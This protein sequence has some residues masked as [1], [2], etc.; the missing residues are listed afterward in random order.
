[1]FYFT[2]VQ[3]LKSGDIAIP[4]V[5]YNTRD[6]YL[7]RYHQEM[8]HATASK[9]FIGCMILVYDG[10]GNILLKDNWVKEIQPEPVPNTEST[11]EE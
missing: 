4:L 1:M 6:E 9:D 5:E 8:A 11:K 2:G 10:N 7:A 3:H